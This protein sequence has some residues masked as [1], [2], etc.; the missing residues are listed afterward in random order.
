[1]TVQETQFDRARLVS[2]AA[3]V[4]HESNRIWQREIGDDVSPPWYIAPTW[5][6][7]SALEGA[8]KHLDGLLTDPRASHES[9]LEHKLRDGWTFGEKKDADAKTHPCCLPYD[10]LPPEQKFKDSLFSAVCD[11]FRAFSVLN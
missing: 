11:A 6:R 4:A 9:W 1:M 3:E 7:E 8:Q 5:Q 10:S 2:I